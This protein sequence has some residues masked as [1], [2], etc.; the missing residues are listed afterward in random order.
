MLYDGILKQGLLWI[1][2][3]VGDILC[4]N[5]SKWLCFDTSI[6]GPWL[7]VGVGGI[8][9]ST[10]S[11]KSIG[12]NIFTS[13]VSGSFTKQTGH[14]ASEDVGIILSFVLVKVGDV[15]F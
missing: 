3:T 14:L 13:Q 9:A 4:F 10:T 2:V 12:H 15:R 6:V 7:Q 11:S 1:V 5:I 8:A